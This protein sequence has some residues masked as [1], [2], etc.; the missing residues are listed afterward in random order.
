MI[1]SWRQSIV[2]EYGYQPQI[3]D[4][5][6]KDPWTIIQVQTNEQSGFNAEKNL[7]D[8]TLGGLPPF[9]RN[10]SNKQRSTTVQMII[11][12]LKNNALR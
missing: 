5:Y 11:S 10:N 1:T 9:L 8:S 3:K 2:M 4:K 12:S 7:R 6:L